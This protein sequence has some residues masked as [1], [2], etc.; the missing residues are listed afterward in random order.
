MAVIFDMQFSW[1]LN[2]NRIIHQRVFRK[3]I[4]KIGCTLARE[5]TSILNMQISPRRLKFKQI[6]YFCEERAAEVK[7]DTLVSTLPRRGRHL[8]DLLVIL[9]REKQW[10]FSENSTQDQRGSN[11]LC[12]VPFS[13]WFPNSTRIIYLSKH[14]QKKIREDRMNI[15]NSR[16]CISILD[17]SYANQPMTAILDMQISW[18]SKSNRI[19][20]QRVLEKKSRRSDKY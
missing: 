3:K 18:F 4:A 15:G 17:T 12:H 7:V 13:C 14:I 11:P 5:C 10:C 16:A 20:H 6:S 8:P 9:R 19:I 2:S 1:F